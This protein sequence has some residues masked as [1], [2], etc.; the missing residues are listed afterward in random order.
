M[1]CTS[2]LDKVQ[3][4]KAPPPAISRHSRPS[5]PAAAVPHSTPSRLP[6]RPAAVRLQLPPSVVALHILELYS[7]IAHVKKSILAALRQGRMLRPA[8]LIMDSYRIIHYRIDMVEGAD[9]ELAEEVEIRA[10][11]LED[12]NLFIV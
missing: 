8:I 11:Q 12:V 3:E 6:H 5:T 4:S 7:A 10:E 2:G 9:L 1:L